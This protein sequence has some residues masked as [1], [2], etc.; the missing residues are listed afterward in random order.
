MGRKRF[1]PEAVLSDAEKSKRYRDKRRAEIEALKAAQVSA[2]AGDEGLDFTEYRETLKA[3]LREQVKTELKLTWEPEAKKER[4]AEAR[5]LARQ[6][7]KQANVDFE[8][9]RYFGII[10]AASHFIGLDRIDITRELLSY[11]HIDRDLAD[12]ILQNDKRTKSLTLTSL[13]K[14]GAWDKSPPVIK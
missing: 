9:G 8:H 4:M 1:N 13:D 14:S 3:Q 7:A 11:Y 2:A 12:R 6:A 5:K 10:T